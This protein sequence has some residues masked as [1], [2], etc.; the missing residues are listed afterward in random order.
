MAVNY[1]ILVDV[2]FETKAIQNKLNKAAKGVSI[3]ANVKGTDSVRD[4]G[5]AVED[6]SLTFAAA[7]EI[8][9]T[10]LDI[11][12]SM[13]KQVFTMDKAMTEFKK[14]SDLSGESLDKYMQKL[15]EAGTT[16]GRTGKPKRQTPVIGMINQ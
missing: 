11:I 3:K 9:H 5:D 10:S 14:V 15:T 16:V 4:L 13:V 1:S 8:F 6:T 2:D 7:N 12:G